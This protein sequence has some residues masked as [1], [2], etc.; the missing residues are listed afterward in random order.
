MQRIL[1]ECDICHED[2]PDEKQ[3]VNLT[4]S[5]FEK[6]EDMWSTNVREHHFCSQCY[7]KTVIGGI[8][9]L[10]NAPQRKKPGPKPKAASGGG[11]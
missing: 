7:N 5:M 10:L 8:D 3:R 9:A 6:P 4:V 1:Y 11:W 2:I